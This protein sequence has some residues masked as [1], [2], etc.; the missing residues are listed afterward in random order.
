MELI[1]PVNKQA[2][3]SLYDFRIDVKLV[4][5]QAFKIKLSDEN[6]ETGEVKIRAE[7]IVSKKISCK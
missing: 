6:R 5:N 3:T 7:G 2:E 1:T 4:S